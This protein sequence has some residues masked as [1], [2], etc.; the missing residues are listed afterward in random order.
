MKKEKPKWAEMTKKQKVIHIIDWIMKSI[1]LIMISTCV[2]Y[3]IVCNAKSRGKIARAN[4]IGGDIGIS[5]PSNSN[6]VLT[7]LGKKYAINHYRETQKTAQVILSMGNIVNT[8][9]AKIKAVK[10]EDRD[11]PTIKFYSEQTKTWDQVYY[12]DCGYG[13]YDMP[14]YKVYTTNIWA[15][16]EERGVYN[17]ECGFVFYP[18]YEGEFPPFE[19]DMI[20]RINTI[21]NFDLAFNY[22]EPIFD[23]ENTETGD[24]LEELN[25]TDSPDFLV[26]KALMCTQNPTLTPDKIYSNAYEE[27]YMTG[28]DEGY[29]E[30][31]NAG[32]ENGYNHGYEEGRSQAT[33][34]NP[35]GMMVEPVAKLLDVKIFGDFSIGNFFTAALFVTLA[36]SF[37]KM[38]AGG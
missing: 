38:F 26:C 33:T 25:I 3:G 16:N 21:G 35:I 2:I 11:I 24:M 13:I 20:A 37:M 15:Y 6:D 29:T 23:Y 30:G 17:T 19:T 34:F 18:Q 9:F 12:F 7:Q 27:G 14:N 36:I 4:V 28:T 31:E 32:Y 8:D 22:K 10:D 1:I 5:T